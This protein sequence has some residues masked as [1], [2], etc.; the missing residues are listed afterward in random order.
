M[1]QSTVRAGWS[2]TALAVLSIPLIIGITGCGQTADSGDYEVILDHP[3]TSAETETNQ[4]TPASSIPDTTP[5]TTA[6]PTNQPPEGGVLAEAASQSDQTTQSTGPETERSSSG[7]PKDP[8]T[9][10]AAA[11]DEEKPVSPSD[12]IGK[13]TAET[14]DGQNDRRTPSESPAAKGSEKTGDATS[15]GS[16][17]QEPSTAKKEPREIKLLIPNKT[18][19]VEGP[20]KALRVSFDDID[21]LKVLNMDPVTENAPELMPKW[22]KD[23]DGKRIRIRGF[24]FPPFEETNIRGFTLARDNQICC[25]GRN[26]LVY[27]LVDVYMRKG[28]TTDYIQNRPFDVVGVFHIGDSII[29]GELYSVD[30]AIVVDE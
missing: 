24:M 27:D 15:G 25:F 19:R 8:T 29:P 5:E 10:P 28:E 26:P 17:K 7:S 9:S 21:L 23:L 13:A 30:D 11:S 14:I 3:D 6:R 4:T 16:P 2:G 20:E 12:T 1:M 18:F 22:L